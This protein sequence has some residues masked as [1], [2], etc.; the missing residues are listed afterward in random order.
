LH[1]LDTTAYEHWERM[2][3]QMKRAEGV[4]RLKACGG[5][6]W[7]HRINSVRSRAE[8]IIRAELILD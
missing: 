6:E 3:G 4:P 2:I 1:E 7:I 8:E 5:M